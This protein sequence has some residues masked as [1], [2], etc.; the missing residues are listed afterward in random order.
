MA[1]GLGGRE[2][3]SVADQV[4]DDLGYTQRIGAHSNIVS[5]WNC[6]ELNVTVRC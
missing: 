1:G 3:Q 6:D 5:W 2:L 4:V